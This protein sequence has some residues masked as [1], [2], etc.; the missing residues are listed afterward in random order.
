MWGGKKIALADL[1]MASRLTFLVQGS[2][3]EPY[4]VRFERDGD[5]LT[6]ACTCAAG[7]SGQYC[8]H[9]IRL[10]QGDLTGLVGGD[11][12]DQVRSML[13]G[14]RLAEVMR[15]VET[16]EAAIDAAKKLL[17]KRLSDAK[18]A[19]ARIMREG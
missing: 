5:R 6:A 2:E 10:L 7:E 12:V 8:K 13:S 9:R 18:H 19:L 14:S 16:E 3:P 15:F 1:R 11:N 4:T 17:A